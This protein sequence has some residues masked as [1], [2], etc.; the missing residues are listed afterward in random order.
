MC[1]VSDGSVRT[2]SI[3]YTTLSALHHVYCAL[4]LKDISKD[5]ANVQLVTALVKSHRKKTYAES[6]CFTSGKLCSTVH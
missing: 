1:E 4:D 5:I 2:G 3:L 6:D